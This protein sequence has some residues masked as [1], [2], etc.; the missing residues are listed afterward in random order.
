MH[1]GQETTEL[2]LS[3]PTGTGSPHERGNWLEQQCRTITGSSEH[4][5][6]SDDPLG[7]GSAAQAGVN[8]ARDARTVP[9]ARNRKPS[10]G[11]YDPSVGAGRGQE[12][13]LSRPL[14]AGPL[15]FF[16]GSTEQWL[17]DLSEQVFRDL[18]SP[19][20]A[21]GEL[22]CFVLAPSSASDVDRFDLIGPGT[23]DLRAVPLAMAIGRLVTALS[24]AALDA[25]PERLHI[26]AA[27]AARGNDAAILA[28]PRETGKTTTITR[29]ALDGWTCISDETVSIRAGDD[30]VRGFS[31]PLSIKP[32]SRPLLPEL[33]P[34]FLP[35]A[36]NDDAASVLHVSLKDIGVETTSAAHPRMVALLRRP[37]S[38]GMSGQPS[39]KP[40]HPAEAVVGLMAETLDA[41]RYGDDAALELARLSARCTCWEVTVG[42]LAETAA[43]IERL[44]DLEPTTH[45]VDALPSGR[46]P[47][48]PNVRSVL[49]GDRVVLHELPEGRIVALDEAGTQIWLQLGGWATSE[50]IDLKAPVVSAFIGQ[51]E[52]LGMLGRMS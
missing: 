45:T 3:R 36:A 19:A 2:L 44:F 16:V 38:P 42:P 12:L 29:L 52:H 15:P 23:G 7:N 31:K 21:A 11:R 8:V 30:L 37:L 4:R 34:H 25:E 40:L 33:Q 26:H 47:V 24:R 39:S 22:P 43:E 35:P 28:A 48:L 9:S 18:P 46:G 27:A 41:G 49:I 50:N 13:L 51:L 20:D 10:S 5:S 1:H 14:L 6:S 17:V 32:G